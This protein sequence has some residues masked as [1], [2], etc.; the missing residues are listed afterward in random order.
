MPRR[1]IRRGPGTSSRI[2]RL[3]GRPKQRWTA[4]NGQVI[5][6]PLLFDLVHVD[7]DT[8]DEL[9]RVEATVDLVGGELALCRMVIQGDAGLDTL[10]LQREFRWLTP[11][12]AVRR[13][14]PAMLADGLDPF[15]Q[16]F[17]FTGYPHVARQRDL[18]NGRLTDEF[19]ED[20]ATEYLAWGRGYAK[21]MADEHQVSRRTAVGWVVKARER[22]ILSGVRPGQYGGELVPHSRRRPTR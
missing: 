10:R 14:V 13:I 1:S 11:L 20:I 18:V 5:E 16:D 17:P 7:P 19:L 15:E 9:W 8:L 6:L 21:R 22:G 4:D 2:N 12:D 3:P